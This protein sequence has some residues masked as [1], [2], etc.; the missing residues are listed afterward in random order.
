MEPQGLLTTGQAAAL[1]GSSRQHVV[2]LCDRGAIPSTSIGRH[3][4]IRRQDVEAFAA[5]NDRRRGLTRDERKSLWLHRAVAGRLALDPDRVLVKARLNLEHLAAV[6]AGE[7]SMGSLE[8]WRSALEAGPD[9]VMRLLGS[10]EPT[11]IELRQNSPFAG[12]LTDA[13]RSAVLRSFRHAS[14]PG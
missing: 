8:T 4:R 6:H 2:D 12:V 14:R 9:A 1:L 13:D 7:A 5:R 11:A 10:E 3:R